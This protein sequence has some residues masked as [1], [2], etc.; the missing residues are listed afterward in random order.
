MSASRLIVSADD[1]GLTPAVDLGIARALAAGSVTAVGVIANLA[2]PARVA[3]LARAHPGTSFG[4]HLNLT[5][6]RPVLP[7]S[8]VPSLIDEGGRFHRLGVLAR[9]ALLGRVVV[10]EAAA[11][12]A[13]QVERLIAAGVAVD[14]VDSHQHVHALPAVAGALVAAVRRTGVRAV[15]S[16]RPLVL[17]V[18][19]E[20]RRAVARYYLRH[21]RRLLTHGWKRYTA[22][23]L[24]RAG[25][26]LPD[27]MVSG[28]LLAHPVVGGPLDEWDAILAELP[29]GTWELVVHPA[30]L[31]AAEGD[32][33]RLGA[34]VE[35]RA[36]EL[37][38][39]VDPRFTRLL[40]RHGV[41]PV[42]FAALVS[43]P[44]AEEEHRARA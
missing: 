19:P 9:R 7:P 8:Q 41:E 24:A 25:L 42:S 31:G 16:H 30:D 37:A 13:A 35:R 29:G 43:S 44:R 21:P 5:V 18:G 27:G 10:D 20:S 14:H 22:A 26:V 11:E 4:V 32:V 15:R 40:A 33:A 28:S 17:A 36:A 1:L 12:L 2:D 3:A 23:S 6:G 39:L 34:L 38:A